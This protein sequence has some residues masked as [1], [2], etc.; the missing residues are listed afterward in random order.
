M[1]VRIKLDNDTGVNDGRTSDASLIGGGAGA[2][3][4]VFIRIKDIETGVVT[5]VPVQ[6]DS[7]GKFSYLPSGLD[8]GKYMIRVADADGNR[9]HFR[10]NLDTTADGKAPVS[11]AFDAPVDAK[12]GTFVTYSVNG[13]DGDARAKVTFT[14][15]NGDTVVRHVSGSG[16]YTVNLG[17]LA[18][19]PITTSF[20]IVDGAKNT[21]TVTDNS[22]VICFFAGTRIATPAGEVAVETLRAGDLVLTSDG[23][24]RPVVWL[25]RQT[26]SRT[27]ADPARVLPIRIAAGALGENQP[28]RDLLVSPDHALLIDGVLVHAAALVNGTTIRRDAA[29]PTLFTYYHVELADHSLVLAEGVPAETFIDS[30]GRLAFDNWH[31]HVAARP[32]GASITELPLP[33]AKSQRQVP[34][35]AR[36]R[37]A[38]RARSLLGADAVAA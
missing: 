23:D 33:R 36:A 1:A 28:V 5:R 26:V 17:R 31:E 22:L 3:G 19:G 4:T 37:I 30:A 15:A 6:A 8:D 12:A 24:P 7:D 29:V 32:D 27:F 10:M 13:L 14:D 25:G 21:T 2:D 9:E 38:E 16:D 34:P 11:V 20:D 35:A 18:D